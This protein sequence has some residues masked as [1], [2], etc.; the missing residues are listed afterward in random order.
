MTTLK[1]SDPATAGTATLHVRGEPLQLGLLVTRLLAIDDGEPVYGVLPTLVNVMITDCV[2]VEI[3]AARRVAAD[4]FTTGTVI[5]NRAVA[6]GVFA[7][8]V[9]TD[10]ACGG[11][12]GFALDDAPPEQSATSAQASSGNTA[13]NNAKNGRLKRPPQRRNDCAWL[14]LPSA[15]SLCFP[16]WQHDTPNGRVRERENMW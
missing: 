14:S 11:T 5:V 6:S 1:V 13:R 4:A 12:A 7:P 16:I 15:W 8:G 3:Y 2:A 10:A 9:A